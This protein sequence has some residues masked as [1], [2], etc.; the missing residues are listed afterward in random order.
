MCDIID[1]TVDTLRGWASDEE[2]AT[3]VPYWERILEK[4]KG[5]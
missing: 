5:E 3:E 4:L 2:I 1:G